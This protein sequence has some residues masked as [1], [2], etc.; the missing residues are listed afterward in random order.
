VV[1]LPCSVSKT[2]RES[3]DVDAEPGLALVYRHTFHEKCIQSWLSRSNECP[4]CKENVV[5]LQ[6]SEQAC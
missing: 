2:R 1:C 3:L 5:A 4:L 6:H